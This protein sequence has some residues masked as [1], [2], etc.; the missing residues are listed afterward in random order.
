MGTGR[1]VALWG[2]TMWEQLGA[3]CPSSPASSLALRAVTGL[4]F[5]GCGTPRGGTPSLIHRGLVRWP[6]GWGPR[7]VLGASGES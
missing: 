4:D 7:V 1:S 5:M 3:D 6:C 2:L